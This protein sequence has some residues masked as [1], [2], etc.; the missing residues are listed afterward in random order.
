[1]AN[2]LDT[3][4]ALSA[5][6]S[7]GAE[8]ILPDDFQPMLATSA[9]APL[10]SLDYGYEVKWDGLRTLVGFE[11]S[12]LFTRTAAG[13]DCRFWFPELEH[14]REPMKPAWGLFDGE[15][16]VLDHGRPSQALLQQRLKAQDY[17]TVER[18]AIEHPATYMVFDVLRIGD[19]WLLDVNWEDRREILP[20]TLERTEDLQISPT[21]RDG[22]DALETTRDLGLEAVMG[23][24]L[25]GRYYP[26]ERTRD[27]LSIRPLETVDAVICGWTEGRGAR[28]STVGSLLLGV[29]R[30]GALT[31]VGHTGTGLGAQTLP[32]IH[33]EMERLSAFKSPFVQTPSLNSEPHWVRPELVCRIRHQGWSD[34][35]Q[36]RAPTFMELVEDRSPEECLWNGA[37]TPGAAR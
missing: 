37:L 24:R 16:V 13:Q 32:Y 9:T 29:Y 30:D 4:Q 7:W 8:T 5:P 33:G 36:M 12:K 3:R 28:S 31:Y 25:R 2:E 22:S 18:L 21:W 14:L 27:W 1:M 10:D 19:S 17:E 34:A 23:K 6:P 15:M 11:R 26:G 20:R 35:G